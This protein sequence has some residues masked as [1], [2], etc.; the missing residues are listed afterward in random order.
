MKYSKENKGLIFTGKELAL[1]EDAKSSVKAHAGN[2]KTNHVGNIILYLLYG[3]KVIKSNDEYSYGEYEEF[4]RYSFITNLNRGLLLISHEIY[5]YVSNVEN[6]NENNYNDLVLDVIAYNS[7]IRDK[8][9]DRQ[10]LINIDRCKNLLELAKY[11]T[12][13]GS[14]IMN[15][16]TYSPEE[17]IDFEFRNGQYGFN[18]LSSNDRKKLITILD[19]FKHD[20][21]FSD[22]VDNF[23]DYLQVFKVMNACDI[24]LGIRINDDNRFVLREEK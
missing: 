22:K 6:H 2:P 13:N 14:T 5:L 9:E 20:Y 12:S 21:E 15:Y 4:G 18:L 3:N 19:R 7:F 17:A 10:W 1:I 11:P 8:D 23:K 16:L 24:K